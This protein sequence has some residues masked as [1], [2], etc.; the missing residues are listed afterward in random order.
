VY[1]GC[2][3][4]TFSPAVTVAYGGNST[5]SSFG[6]KKEIGV[7]ATSTYGSGKVFAICD[8]DIFSNSH[9][10]ELDNENLARNLVN[11]S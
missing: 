5:K 2:S 9:I 8:S 1:D 6:V 3:I 7:I 4:D 10:K 11:W